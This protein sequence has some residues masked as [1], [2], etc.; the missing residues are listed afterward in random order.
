MKH[1]PRPDR[2]T[3]I[4][5]MLTA[6]ASTTMLGRIQLGAADSASPAE[7]AAT[8]YGTDPDMMRAYKP[9]DVWPLTFTDVQRATA[10]ALCA[11]IIPA[12]DKSPSAAD[13]GVHDF[14]DEWISAPYP[15][16]M[17][18]RPVILDGLAWIGV[19]SQRR[20]GKTFAELDASSEA[21]IC[22]DICSAGRAAPEFKEAARFFARFRDLTAGGFYTTPEGMRDIGY[23]GN[24]ALGAFLGPP[25]E[26]LERLGLA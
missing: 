17:R 11:V 18:D 15:D 26:V 13:L 6:A 5:W 14:I 22:D 19:E 16:Q 10:A 25:P 1:H 20:F 8:G 7:P 24:V 23:T 4:K 3:A 2:R 12:D 9:G 21:A